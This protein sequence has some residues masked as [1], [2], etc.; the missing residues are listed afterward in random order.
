MKWIHSLRSKVTIFA[1]I[2]SLVPLVSISAYVALTSKESMHSTTVTVNEALT[3][4]LIRSMMGQVGSKKATI[5]QYLSDAAGQVQTFSSAASVEKAMVDFTAD[6][7]AMSVTGD[8]TDRSGVE[9]YWTHSFGSVYEEQTGHSNDDIPGYLE[10]LD[11]VAWKLQ[12]LYIS[13]NKNPLGS[14]ERLD[15]AEGPAAYNTT[16]AA[17]HPWARS[18]LETFGYYDVF[19]VEPNDGRIVYSVFK[20]LDFGT[21][22]TDGPWRDT[23]IARA[24]KKALQLSEGEVV[25][26]DYALYPPSYDAPATFIASPVVSN[27]SIIGVAIV[28]LP[29]ERISQTLSSRQGLGATGEVY[30]VGPDHLLRTDSLRFP[31]QFNVTRSF[32]DPDESQIDS[33]A[34]DM[35]LQGDTGSA[36]YD[37]YHGE[38]VFAAYTPI[39]V[40]G[41]RWALIAE[42]EKSEA[43][44]RAVA[45]AEESATVVQSRIRGLMI[46]IAIVIPAIVLLS[47]LFATVLTRP[48]KAITAALRSVANGQL[49]E[50]LD[51]Y[52]KG[53]FGQMSIA[54]NDTIKGVRHAIGSDSVDWTDDFSAMRKNLSRIQSMVEGAPSSIVMLNTEGIITYVNPAARQLFASYRQALP[55]SHESLEGESIEFLFRQ[56]AVLVERIIGS[57]DMPPASIVEFANEMFS[58]SFVAIQDNSGEY[59]GPMLT[60]EVITEQLAQQKRADEQNQRELDTR[61]AQ[62]HDIDALL[63]GVNAA[64]DGDLTLET[65]EITDP[66][67][68][69]IV[70]GLERLYQSLRTSFQGIRQNAVT[71]ADAS[72][73]LA[74]IGAQMENNTEQTSDEAK[75]VSFTASE[76]STSVESVAAATEQMSACIREIAGNATQA[77]NTATSAVSLADKTEQSVKQLTESSLGISSIVKVI[78]SIAEQTNLLA[79]NATIEAAR[80]GDAGKGFAVVANE[81]KELAKETSKA[82]DEISQRIIAIQSDSQSA[83][84][85]IRDINQ[86]IKDI[87]ETQSMISCAVQEQDSTTNEISKAIAGAATGN[88]DIAHGIESVS[89]RAQ[90][91]LAGTSRMKTAASELST[92]GNDLQALVTR[93]KIDKAG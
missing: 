73:T 60:L 21:S 74:Q 2:V 23:G 35:A 80:A 83:T 33:K 41:N 87:N 69:Q 45:I 1:L 66:A 29:L 88:Q 46:G 19:L 9:K 67:V 8:S 38:H 92:M 51:V 89:E 43:L 82:T 40:L 13:E 63:H 85:A 70:S 61:A 71:V 28:Q 90:E 55:A 18:M 7:R 58:V 48:L 16:H 17:F 72:T 32:R 6:V 75:S 14:K 68:R 36:D 54:F 49:T 93:F 52:G 56:N 27:G 12:D 81:V 39:D 65:P 22:L 57:P 31:E 26:D 42:M 15:R 84:T 86:V 30:A 4:Q 20:E 62:Q 37:S 5:E 53:E 78:T 3:E 25:M 34:V 77:V 11:P 59:L 50:T 79:L 47:I 76:V 44:Q 10:K 24:Y 64:A 91:T